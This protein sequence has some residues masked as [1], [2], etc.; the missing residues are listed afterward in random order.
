MR[1][2]LLEIKNF[3]ICNSLLQD[4]MHTLIVSNC[5]CIRTFGYKIYGKGKNI[6]YINEKILNFPYGFLDID[7]KPTSKIDIEHND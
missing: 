1:S 5:V 6:N 2:P 7:K 4:P 3:N